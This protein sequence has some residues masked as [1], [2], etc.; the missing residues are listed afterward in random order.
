MQELPRD[1]L[2]C[3]RQPIF[4]KVEFWYCNI[5]TCVKDLI[6]NPL[7]D[8]DK[9]YKPTKVYWDFEGLVQLVNEAW[10]GDWMWDVQVSTTPKLTRPA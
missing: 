9:C 8:G 10:T 2:N 7:F 1:K 3:H 4:E 5:V 6:S